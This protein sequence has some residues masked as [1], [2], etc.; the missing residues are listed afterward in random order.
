MLF[1]EVVYAR[2]HEPLKPQCTLEMLF[3]GLSI[4]F[5]IVLLAFTSHLREGFVVIPNISIPTGSATEGKEA[6]ELNV[7][8]RSI[9]TY[10]SKNP[11]KI[12]PFLQDIKDK[13]FE[14]SCQLK[15]PAPPVSELANMYRPIFS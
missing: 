14:P 2:G 4:L 8:W 10:M 6:E 15:Q 7:C 11:G 12:A 1:L 5:L 3:L 9:L 13:L